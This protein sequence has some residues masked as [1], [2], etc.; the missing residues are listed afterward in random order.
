MKYII[1]TQ[2][3]RYTGYSFDRLT[4]RPDG[5]FTDDGKDFADL[6]KY[7]IANAEDSPYPYPS[8]YADGY[9]SY[10]ASHILKQIREADSNII[11]AS[12]VTFYTF[13]YRNNSLCDTNTTLGV[14]VGQRDWYDKALAL[15]GDIEKLNA[16]M[17]KIGLWL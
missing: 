5:I 6:L 7:G 16:Y 1:N 2:C 10:N 13:D 11:N 17:K 14:G 12:E 3:E 15:R 4:V 9:A 8:E